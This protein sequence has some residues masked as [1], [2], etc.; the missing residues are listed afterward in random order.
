MVRSANAIGKFTADALD[1]LQNLHGRQLTLD[2]QSEE[3]ESAR[4]EIQN[5]LARFADY[6]S[7]ESGQLDGRWDIEEQS[8]RGIADSAPAMIWISGTDKLCFWFN[9]RWLDFTGRSLEQ[10]MGNGWVNGVHPDDVRY[11]FEHY[12]SHFDRREPFSMEYRLRRHDGQ[13]CWIVDSGVPH[14]DEAGVFCGY[15]GSC[16]DIHDIKSVSNRIVK[17]SRLYA[18]ISAANQALVR[19]TTFEDVLSSVCR[20]SV[21]QGGF[22]LAWT[23]FADPLGERL[24]AAEMFG[25]GTNLMKDLVLPLKDRLSEGD[26]PCCVAYREERV[27]VANNYDDLP[28]TA[29]WHNVIASLGFRAQIALPLRRNRKVVG[30]FAAFGSERDIFDDAAV[31]LLTELSNNISFA[32]DQH[33]KQ[34]RHEATEVALSASEQ[35]FKEAFTHT[36]IGMAIVD[37]RGQLQW[38]NPAYCRMTG[39]SEH[40][41]RQFNVIKFIHPDEVVTHKS[42]IA[43]VL[44]GDIDCCRLERRLIHKDGHVVL[45]WVNLCLVRG[46]G[47]KPL[48]FMSQCEHISQRRAMERELIES[49]EKLRALSVH[50]ERRLEEERKHIAR[51][52]H[53][54]LGQLLSLLKMDICMLRDSLPQTPG[55]RDKANEMSSLVEKTIGVV[56]NVAHNLRPAVLDL[57]LASAISWLAEDF[58][59]GWGISCRVDAL[60]QCLEV[61]EARA[62]VVFRVVQESLTNIA[63]HARASEVV[64]VLDETEGCQNLLIRDNGMGFD[65]AKVQKTGRGLGLLGMR[66]R[67][68]GLGG[69]LDIDTQPGCGTVIAIKLPLYGKG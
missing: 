65:S 29:S 52:L 53:D 68:L 40:E 36:P 41:L 34:I 46:G 4:Q 61:D 16:I 69:T 9:K 54:E 12:A 8:F 58:S 38:A 1:R 18:T 57:G 67:V 31:E 14:Y 25:V 28:T 20:A 66:E 27:V 17:V 10:E 59:R 22:S 39:Y 32:L 62:T 5:R 26:G 45:L 48:Y 11:C 51:E 3:F 7:V 42:L 2:F 33:A 64:I 30:V 21:E 35:R 49:K 47:G 56:R 15:M 24:E 44:S 43:R 19:S 55:L 60:S 50:H 6:C 37:L 23:G 13:Y 63:R